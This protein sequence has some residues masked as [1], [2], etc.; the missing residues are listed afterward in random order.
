MLLFFICVS[1][2]FP[3]DRLNPGVHELSEGAAQQQKNSPARLFFMSERAFGSCEH[4]QRRSGKKPRDWQIHKMN[5]IERTYADASCFTMK[6]GEAGR[7][8]AR[9][10]AR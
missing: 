2:I 5:T 6:G 3:C 1:G 10:K 9:A 8:R 7:S 4:A